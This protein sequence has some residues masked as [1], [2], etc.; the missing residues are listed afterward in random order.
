[1]ERRH[2]RH[3]NFAGTARL[4][5]RAGAG[6]RRPGLQV[7]DPPVPLRGDA[8]RARPR[9][10]LPRHG[11]G[12]ARPRPPRRRPLPGQRPVD[13]DEDRDLGGRWFRHGRSSI[14]SASGRS[15]RR[16]RSTARPWT[17]TL[18]PHIMTPS[19]RGR[20]AGP[21]DGHGARATS[22]ENGLN[23]IVVDPPRPWLGIVAGGHACEQV[24]G[25]AAPRSGS[26]PTAL[27]DARRARAEA[28]RAQPVRRRGD[29]PARRGHH[30]AARR[31]GQVA[32]RR[33]AGP[34]RAATAAPTSPLVLGKRDADGQ[35]LVPLNGRA[36]G[37]AV[38]SSRCDGSSPWRSRPSGWPRP[39]PSSACSS[40]SAP[41]PSERRS[42]APAAR[43]TPAPSSRRARSSAP[44]S[45]ATAWSASWAAAREGTITGI[46]QMGGEG[47]QWIGIAPFVGRP[48]PVPEHRR[49]HVLPLRPARRC[50]PRWRPASTS[51]SSSSTT[52]RWP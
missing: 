12:R 40:R 48:P 6:R 50:R 4:R 43:T 25:G 46:T 36:H 14:P 1:M 38:W 3:G 39:A 17:P 15:S 23:R 31:R 47:S 7:L 49:R 37:R 10:P 13:G 28:R 8:G 9:R 30:D 19:P 18:T 24:D 51:P 45:A 2:I 11:A 20:G 22:Q 21:A 33:D 35:A 52:P 16:S 42:S 27:A 29:A 44:A 26:T 34:G 5:R 32:E 41:R